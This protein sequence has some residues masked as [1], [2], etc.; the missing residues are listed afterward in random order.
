M[1]A[2][3]SCAT[4]SCAHN[5]VY[6]HSPYK[7]FVAEQA[8]SCHKI[9]RQKKKIH[10]LWTLS[11]FLFEKGPGIGGKPPENVL[12]RNLAPTEQTSTTRSRHNIEQFYPVAFS[13]QSTKC[14]MCIKYTK[15][16]MVKLNISNEDASNKLSTLILINALVG[17]YPRSLVEALEAVTTGLKEGNNAKGRIGNHTRSIPTS[18]T[19][20]IQSATNRQIGSQVHQGQR[21]KAPSKP[22]HRSVTGQQSILHHGHTQSTSHSTHWIPHQCFRNIMHWRWGWGLTCTPPTGGS[23]LR[24]YPW[25][26][27]LLFRRRLPL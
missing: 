7:L 26:P 18:D 13:L 10:R 5:S 16:T 15:C 21:H 17:S 4:L 3:V 27:G 22:S 11:S 2:R 24:Q 12:F 6:V 25:S 19:K 8:K 23:P 20:H 9:D 14:T 1:C